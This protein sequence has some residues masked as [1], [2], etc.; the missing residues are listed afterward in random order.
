MKAIEAVAPGLYIRVPIHDQHTTPMQ[1]LHHAGI[2]RPPYAAMR[3][4]RLTLSWSEG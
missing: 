2:F 3:V 1:I 4:A